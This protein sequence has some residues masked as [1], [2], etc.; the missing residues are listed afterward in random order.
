MKGLASW[1]SQAVKM[2]NLSADEYFFPCIE[3]Y[4]SYISMHGNI[5]EA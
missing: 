2:A 1:Q 4:I 3:C 5:P